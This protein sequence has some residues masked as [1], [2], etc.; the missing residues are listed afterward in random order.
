[1]DEQTPGNLERKTKRRQGRKWNFS[2]KDPNA[3][4]VD[5][6]TVEKRERCMKNRLCFKCEKKGH[7]GR[8]CPPEE[9]KKKA[10]V[11]SFSPRKMMLR[12]RPIQALQP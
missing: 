1:L 10:P 6:M 2:K 7:L 11:A 12:L 4:D 9:D 5:V 8:D 3:M